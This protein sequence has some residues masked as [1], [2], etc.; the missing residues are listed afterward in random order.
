MASTAAKFH[1]SPFFVDHAHA[2]RDAAYSGCA[3]PTQQ[4]LDEA[5]SL[6]GQG[7]KKVVLSIGTTT[8]KISPPTKNLSRVANA[9]VARRYLSS[10]PCAITTPSSQNRAIGLV[11]HLV[12]MASDAART[13][14]KV[15]RELASAQ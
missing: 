13:H 7:E 6:W 2:Y 10:I 1:F 3:N 12:T 11:Q 14:E 15:K 4:A 9:S 5:E 8:S